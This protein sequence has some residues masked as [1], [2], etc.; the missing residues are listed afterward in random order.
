M[1]PHLARRTSHAAPFY[2]WVVVAG[3]F[4]VMFTGFG[5]AYSFGAFFEPLRDEF[6]ATRSEVSLVFA[7]TAFLYFG[8]GA[9]SGRIAD[10]VGPRRVIVAGGVLLGAGLLAAAATQ[11]LWQV[12]LTY[13]L[14]VGVGIGLSYVPSVG[15]VQRWFVRRRG[16]ASGLAVAG[17]G[18]G[19]LVFPPA[20]AKL[21]D[22]IG[23]RESYVALGVLV[24][25]STIA[26][27]LLIERDPS[28]RGQ[29][30]DGDPVAAG[31]A[32]ATAWGMT[33]GEA[34][35]TRPYRLLYLAGVSTS[36]GLFIPFV[37]IVPYAKDHGLSSFTGAV[38]L[39]AIGAGS[40][41]GRLALGGSADR[42]G[43]RQALAG[44]FLLMAAMLLVWL[45]ATQTWSLLLF[46][47]VFGVGYGGFVALMPALTSDYFGVRHAGALLGLLYTGAGIGSLVGPTLAG[48]A[49]DLTDSY[50][51][52]IL[53]SAAANLVA[54][55][56][57]I[58]I[59][60]PRRFRASQQTRDARL[61][62]LAG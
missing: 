42:V 8:L 16:F 19:N 23:W 59:G 3:A 36:L 28:V 32:A 13:S 31:G 49:F 33:T 29:A 51:L 20:A 25:V 45:A 52:P 7:V 34:L 53:F 62:P 21:I 56:C 6:G 15:A 39:G 61:A 30:P 11:A 4:L 57:M 47:F 38:I 35:R 27:A 44:S 22:A 2:G 10:R 1:S 24:L 60:D 40:A 12:Y 48:W 17:I 9:V 54:V 18:L 46:A 26:G 55:A 50:T 58:A 41:A 37:H 5:A 14:C 43:R